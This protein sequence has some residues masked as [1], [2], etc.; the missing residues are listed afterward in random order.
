MNGCNDQKCGNAYRALDGSALF[1]VT[2]GTD[3]IPTR[4]RY[5]F[6]FSDRFHCGH[7]TDAH[8]GHP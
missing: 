7:T 6:H 4:L 8:F 5:L 1:D 2:E 3:E